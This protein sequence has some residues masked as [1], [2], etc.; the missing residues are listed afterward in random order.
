M[1]HKDSDSKYNKILIVTGGS[2]CESILDKHIH[3]G[4]YQY[5]IGVDKGLEALRSL[6]ISPNLAIG[7]FDSADASIRAI[8]E[9][10]SNAIILNPEKDY[11]DTHVA[12]EK[13]LEKEPETIVLLGATGTRIDHVLGNLAL[14]KLCL[15]KGV[16]LIIEDE[17][18]RIYMTDSKATV[19]KSEAYG[20]YVS[21][22]PFSDKVT[23]IN[24]KGFKY[25]LECATF[26]KEE[27]LG[28]SNEIREEEGQIS[29]GDGY[30]IILETKD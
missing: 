10:N 16:K 28:V 3:S 14:L 18:N 6:N 29:I 21:L 11:T 30:L 17:N 27:T 24:L 4:E 26:V 7:D 2:V 13:A 9:N 25:D 12:V 19:K 23:D 8:Y 20:K 15:V 22:I 5:V 1:N